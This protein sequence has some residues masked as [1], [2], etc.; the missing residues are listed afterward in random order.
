MGSVGVGY[1]NA[2]A[3]SFFATLECELFSR[4]SSLTHAKARA[5]PSKFIEIFYNRQRLHPALGFLSRAL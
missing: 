1:D 5:A 2:M 4:S 3:E